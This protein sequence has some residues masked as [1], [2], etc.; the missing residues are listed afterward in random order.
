MAKK[1]KTTWLSKSEDH[2]YPAA[3]SYLGLLY[4]EKTLAMKVKKLRQAHMS[5]FKA[6]DILRAS[7]SP[8]LSVN[9]FHVKKDQE[10]ILSRKK[11]SP[12]L[13]V[14]D[15]KNGKLVIA[16]GYHR[17]CAVYFYDEDAVIPCKI[18]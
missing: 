4:D 3:M 6:K 2:D 9:N 17:M 14:R 12:L 13:L 8:L 15:T 10:K 16:D 5:Y 18:I 7:G 1:I 11:L